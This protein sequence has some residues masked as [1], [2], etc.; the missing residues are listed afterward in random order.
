MIG[1]IG[2]FSRRTH[3]NEYRITRADTGS[4]TAVECTF[5]SLEAA[6]DFIR[7]NW[8]GRRDQQDLRRI[9]EWAENNPVPIES[10]KLDDDGDFVYSPLREFYDHEST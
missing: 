4:L 2:L 6:E 8:A 5:P 1:P 7:T 3:L 9:V 10:W